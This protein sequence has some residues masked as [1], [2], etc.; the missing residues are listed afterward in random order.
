MDS[1]YDRVMKGIEEIVEVNDNMRG[2]VDSIKE[3]LKKYKSSHKL[4]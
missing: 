3:K 1:Y 4:A 2:K